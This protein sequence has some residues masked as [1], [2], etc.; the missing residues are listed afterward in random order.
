[1]FNPVFPVFNPVPVAVRASIQFLATIDHPAENP[2]NRL[3]QLQRV[4]S[5]SLTTRATQP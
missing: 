1:M 5:V 2:K 4:A 3:K